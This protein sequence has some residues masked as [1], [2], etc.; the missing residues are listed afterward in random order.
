MGCPSVLDGRRKTV[1]RAKCQ[2]SVGSELDP[3]SSFD[4]FHVAIDIL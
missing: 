2:E 4:D 3:S 1:P